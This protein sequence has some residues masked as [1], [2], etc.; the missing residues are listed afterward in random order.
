VYQSIDPPRR[1]RPPKPPSPRA[2]D[3]TPYAPIAF[4]LTADYIKFWRSTERCAKR[5]PQF[6]RDL[7]ATLID[8]AVLQMSALARRWDGWGQPGL[9][10]KKML[11]KRCAAPFAKALAEAL[12][13]EEELSFSSLAHCDDEGNEVP[14]DPANAT[15]LA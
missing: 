11:P 9:Y 15:R 3:W 12:G 7:H 13:P 2:F 4:R 8:E 6:W 1:G 10:L 14:F 5:P